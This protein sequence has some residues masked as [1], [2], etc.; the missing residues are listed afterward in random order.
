MSVG[1]HAINK[2]LSGPQHSVCGETAIV[3][4]SFSFVSNLTYGDDDLQLLL[5]TSQMILAI[6]HIELL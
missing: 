3:M 2:S 1:Y 5:C 6:L 4:A